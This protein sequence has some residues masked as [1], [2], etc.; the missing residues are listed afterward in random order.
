MTTSPTTRRAWLA[1]VA[2]LGAL[3][4]LSAPIAALAQAARARSFDGPIFDAHLHYNVEAWQQYPLSDVLAR[5]QRSGVRAVLANSRPNEGTKKLAATRPAGDASGVQVVP[6]VRLYRDRADY[7]NWFRD[8]SIHAM[9]LDEL[10]QGTQAGPYRGIGEFHL[11]DSKNADGPVAVQLMQLARERKLVVLAHCDEVAIEKLLAHAPATATHKAPAVI[12]AHTGIGGVPIER[13]RELLAQHPTLFGEL[14][15]RPGLT[16]ADGRLSPT[17]RE[18]LSTHSHRFM[19][20]S[21]TWTNS[22]WDQYESLMQA[23]RGWL[24]DL[25]LQAAQRIA[26]GNGADLFGLR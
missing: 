20:G 24:A 13:V 1:R 2:R 26:W 17:W 3:T 23:A 22:R 5:M 16:A 14:S 12:W 21:D 8:P 15:Y 9:V 25:P 6:L 11:Y 7:D 19:V 10:A 18:L 4:T